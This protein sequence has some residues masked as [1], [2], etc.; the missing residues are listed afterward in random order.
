MNTVSETQPQDLFC[1]NC[2]VKISANEATYHNGLCQI[3]Y[4]REKNTDM[5]SKVNA[6]LDPEE[7]Q[8]MVF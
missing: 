2:G 4:S 5:A 8:N 7:E 1:L 6:W 3:C